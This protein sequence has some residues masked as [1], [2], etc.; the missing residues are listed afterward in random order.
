[1]PLSVR[2]ARRLA[3]G[4]AAGLEQAEA[5]AVEGGLERVPAVA[6]GGVL[7]GESRGHGSYNRRGEESIPGCVKFLG[8]FSG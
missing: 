2:S 8:K 5:R 1:M 7:R 3:G 6:A 4:G